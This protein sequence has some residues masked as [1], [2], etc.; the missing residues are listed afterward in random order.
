MTHIPSIPNTISKCIDT[1]NIITMYRY[2]IVTTDGERQY[3]LTL[4]N[5]RG[6]YSVLSL[7]RGAGFP[8]PLNVVMFANGY[9][10]TSR[11]SSFSP[12]VAYN[13]AIPRPFDFYGVKLLKLKPSGLT[14]RFENV[15]LPIVVDNISEYF[16]GIFLIETLFNLFNVFYISDGVGTITLSRLR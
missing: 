3:D 15:I 5:L 2:T 16:S 11:S 7:Y 14:I 1:E 8:I 10:N 13:G 12:N 4:S 9:E 6:I